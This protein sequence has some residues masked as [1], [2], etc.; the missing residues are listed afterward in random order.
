[1]ALFLFLC[2]FV[3]FL[4]YHCIMNRISTLITSS[5]GVASLEVAEQI[6]LPTSVDVQEVIKLVIQLAIGIATIINL[7][8]KKENEVEAT[9]TGKIR[10]IFSKKTKRENSDQTPL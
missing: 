8:R 6:T 5:I 3:V 9:D 2:H 7:F 1:M 4:Y 10:R